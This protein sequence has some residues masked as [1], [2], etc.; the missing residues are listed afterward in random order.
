[1][2]KLDFS[3]RVLR[4]IGL[5]M[6]CAILSISCL[7]PAYAAPPPA[8]NVT[9][10]E[11]QIII[12]GYP[13]GAT[14]TVYTADG[15]VYR[16]HSN[17]PAYSTLFVPALPDSRQYYVTQTVNGEESP[18]SS[19]VNPPLRAPV[20]TP[21][22]E[23]IEVSNVSGSASLRLF[24]ATTGQEVTANAMYQGGNV[25]RL[26]NVVPHSDLYY[27]TQTMNGTTS[28]NSSSVTPS[29]RVLTAT[30]GSGHVGVSNVYPGATVRLH[31]NDGMIIASNPT[32]LGGGAYRFEF[33][34]QG[35][36]YY[37]TQTINGITS[38]DSSRV[39]VTEYFPDAPAVTGGDESITVSQYV[40]GATLKL[41]T[42]T[43]ILKWTILNVPGLS[44]TIRD[45]LPDPD[46]Y[47]V[48]QTVSGKESVNSSF[49]NPT[50]RTPVV[51]AG[52]E[53]IDI[54]NVSDRTELKL[55]NAST[56]QPVPAN[57]EFQGNGVYRLVDVAPHSDY[58]YVMQ[59]IHSISSSNST[60]VTPSLRV[61]S[62]T[63]G[64]EF[65]DV[66]N[67]YPGAGVRLH[68]ND[69]TI[70]ATN[71]TDQGGGVYRFESVASGT[72]YYATQIINGIHSASS[73][74]VVVTDNTPVAPVA[75]GDEEAITVTHFVSGAILKL[76]TTTGV[77]KGTYP[78]ITDSSYTITDVLPDPD[79]YYVTQT[80]N[81]RES[82]NSS[83][84][85]STLRTPVATAGIEYIDVSNVSDRTELK[86]YNAS[87]GQS[88][89]ANVESRGHGVYRLINVV[90]HSD[91]YYVTQSI[92]GI[93][94]SNSTFV[95][96]SLRVPSATGGLKSVDVTNIYPD[97]TVHLHRQDGTIVASNPTDLGGGVYRFNSV[98]AGT[99]YYVTQRINGI[100]SSHSNQVV[101]TVH[102]P[103][104]P[105]A[106]GGEESITVSEYTPG[107]TL[108]L[109]TG[110]GVLQG[111]YSSVTG[112]VYTLD[113]ILPHP[114]Y[115]Y[116]TQTLDGEESVNSSFFNPL[117]RTP[118]VTA[119]VEYI[120]V[121]NVSAQAA[122]KLYDAANHNVVSSTYSDLGNGK[123]RF[124]HVVP[125]SEFYYVTQSVYGIES[126]NSVFVNPVLR[127]PVATG[128]R[129]TVEVTN[130]Y[131]GATL[132]LY[133]ASSQEALAMQPTE[134]EN[135]TYRFSNISSRGSYYVVQ[136][137]NGV[138]S[139]QSN[140]VNVT[141][142]SSSSS[143]MDSGNNSGSSVPPVQTP[144]TPPVDTSKLVNV[145]VNGQILK[146]GVLTTSTQN[147]QTVHSIQMDRELI[148]SVL[149]DQ[150]QGATVTVPFTDLPTGDAFVANF[151][152]DLMREMQQASTL[153]SVQT[154]SG[155]YTVSAQQIQLRSPSSNDMSNVDVQIR[156]TA[157]STVQSEAAD[158]AATANQLER[159]TPPVQFDITEVSDGRSIAIDRYS[160]YVE[161][162]VPI[163][164]DVQPD[165]ITTAV[166]VDPDGSV[167]HVP[168]RI[169]NVDGRWYA[170]IK[171]LSNSSYMLVRQEQTFTDIS[172]SWARSSIENMGNRLIVSGT[173][174]G[175]FQP[176]R[177]I[178]RAE[179]ASILSK[180]LG[181]E[182][183]D[184]KADFADVSADSWYNGSVSAAVDSGLIT[185]FTDGTFRPGQSITRA[186]AMVMLSRAMTLTGL[187]GSASGDS[188]AVQ[189]FTDADRVPDWARE[190]AASSVQAGLITGLSGNRLAPEQV[191]TRAEIATILERLL[192]ESGLI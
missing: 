45:V 112:S 173:G 120:D 108:K 150:P 34:T 144:V 124:E 11:E 145:L 133:R 154:T 37:V 117:L 119:G 78:N 109:Y 60:F 33:I 50:L 4:P 131:P 13:D 186:E 147:G 8:P 126:I 64:G 15:Q 5:M 127:T 160:T 183:A 104:A 153:L 87:T 139:P 66:S 40:S 51:T 128:G 30:G 100:T 54:S 115:Y 73:N 191:V 39:D 114:D 155:H 158:R 68:R 48:T 190:A 165:R 67:V 162:L 17:L 174:A 111:I 71:P 169:V 75:T 168:T 63:G 74:A 70:I 77:L 44:Y 69:G 31:R 181:L 118:L 20:V 132:R 152:G 26:I 36:G 137:I 86:L 156:V 21:G 94:S 171:S 138:A 9:I 47:Y 2:N 83:F 56:G 177:A 61:P 187:S 23:Y 105:L 6:L 28:S 38:A 90:P 7:Q 85:N 98:A 53:Y 52:L 88:V 189:Q 161:G 49:V 148:R 92:D 135:S 141:T 41:Y 59:S 46:Q 143:D 176:Q 172:G 57:V 97:A 79:Q 130:V 89:A 106:I 82:L 134:Q 175:Q 19:Y 93:S 110:A 14:I 192:R 3:K 159:L 24:N 55:F 35:T 151:D 62:V 129:N 18:P 178:T 91:Y 142:R 170:S 179:F 166:A 163:P 122:L 32:A 123:Y 58:Y 10:G 76:Y 146:A 42:T 184:D 1:M 72:G 22:V 99:G 16:T 180:G 157:A 80:V 167:R 84:I 25:Y 103:G 140:A 12:N 188:T 136:M 107:A 164:E 182:P 27:V 65:V 185:G 101:V 113:D 125:Q 121:S 96:P 43:G 29:L 95:T 102:I 149:N 116:M 81:G